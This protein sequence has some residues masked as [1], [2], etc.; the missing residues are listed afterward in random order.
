MHRQSAKSNQYRHTA[1]MAMM[2]LCVVLA[3]ALVAKTVNANYDA[4]G[5]LSLPW[6]TNTTWY[7]NGPHNWADNRSLP[8]NSLD[9]NGNGGSLIY[10]VLAARGG[11][12]H[13]DGK[14]SS[15]GYVRL[16]HG[17]GWSTTYIHLSSL[18]VTESTGWVDRGV[19]LGYTGQNIS[20]FGSA[21]AN[22]V[23]F[24]IWYAPPP[25]ALCLPVGSCSSQEVWWDNNAGT[26]VQIGNYVWTNGSD[27][28][29]G[30]DTNIVTNGQTC[31]VNLL[32]NPIYNDGAI[33]GNLAISVISPTAGPAVGGTTVLVT[34][35]G[36]QGLT[37]PTGVQFGGTNAAS[38]VVNSDTQ[39]TAVSPAFVPVAVDITVTN[40]G[41]TS[42]PS[43][44]D[45]FT[46]GPCASPSLTPNLASPQQVDS[47]VTFTAT[48]TTCPKPEYEFYLQ[49]PGQGWY[50]EQG[51]GGP[52]WSWDT[53]GVAGVGAFNV[54]VWVR[55]T[56]SRGS[57]QANVI[58]PFTLTNRQACASL[59]LTPNQA[60]PQ[61]VDSTIVFTATS[62]SC[63]KPEYL[64]YLQPPGQSW[65]LMQGWGGA[66][67]S[68][69]TSGV[70]SVGTFNVDVWVRE[71]GS[72][73]TN[74]AVLVVPYTLTNRQACAGAWLFVDQ[75]SPIMRGPNVTFVGSSVTCPKPEYEIWLQSPGPNQP[76]VLVQGYGPAAWGWNTSSVTNV[77]AYNV[78]VWVREIGSA[79]NYQDVHLIA[80]TVT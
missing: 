37:G 40:N 11:Y 68:W 73:V 32:S 33:A 51:W 61:Q 58:V 36:F 42:P 75:P 3:G 19:Q 53:F 22:H 29:Y 67:W 12:V 71:V 46:Y 48:S 8:W 55:E 80:Y 28:Y 60:S 59:T 34:G 9:L 31:F 65:T 38:Y 62:V 70:A 21:N 64:F 45:I 78:D 20:C 2:I 30:C 54:N 23:H 27:Q 44:S 6:A 72:G 50:L 41:I 74:Q 10:P 49:P 69:D 43:D 76:W 16:D 47:T 63:P 39:I 15:C 57:A 5:Q 26:K 52:T 18:S 79:V 14:A 66:T 35:R 25:Q 56:G 77:G 1:I 17:G 13:L 4:S 7:W 24:S